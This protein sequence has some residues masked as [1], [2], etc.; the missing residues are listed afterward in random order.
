[1]KFPEKVFIDF[2]SDK[3]GESQKV[4]FK[5]AYYNLMAMTSY[6][7]HNY[8]MTIKYFEKA[9]KIYPDFFVAKQNKQAV[10]IMKKKL[11][12]KEETP[13]PTK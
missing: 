4:P 12:A 5:A 7:L 11:E 3:K 8:D 1:M 10:E 9:L 2:P 13:K 6:D